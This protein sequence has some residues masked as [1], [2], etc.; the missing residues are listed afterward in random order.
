[1]NQY[2]NTIAIVEN[3]KI[4]NKIGILLLILVERFVEKS[5]A[6]IALIYALKFVIEG[7]AN[8]VITKELS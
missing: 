5:V 8:P 3:I 7:N 1:M 6:L 2:L 4:L